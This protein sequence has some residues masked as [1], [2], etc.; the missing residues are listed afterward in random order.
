ME[1]SSSSAA[2]KRIGSALRI[3]ARYNSDGVKRK[4]SI[5]PIIVKTPVRS[6]NHNASNSSS[7]S[8]SPFRVNSLSTPSR[9]YSTPTKNGRRQS[10]GARSPT[11]VRAKSPAIRKRKMSLQ[12][13]MEKARS[14]SQACYA[15]AGIEGKEIEA[16]R[17]HFDTPDK[18]QTWLHLNDVRTDSWEKASAKSVKDLWEEVNEEKSILVKMEGDRYVMRVMR[19]V[20]VVV[21][22]QFRPGQYRYLLESSQEIGSNGIVVFRKML[23]AATMKPRENCFYAAKRGVCRELANLQSRGDFELTLSD[24]TISRGSLHVHTETSH[25]N[26]YPGL[27]TMYI[28]HTVNATTKKKLPTTDFST[29]EYLPTGH[30]NVKHFWKWRTKAQIDAV[31]KTTRD[32]GGIS[33]RGSSSGTASRGGHGGAKVLFTLTEGLFQ[34]ANGGMLIDDIRREMLSEWDFTEDEVEDILEGAPRVVTLEI[35][36]STLKPKILKGAIVACGDDNSDA[37]PTIEQEHRDV[38]WKLYPRATRLRVHLLHGGF[39]GAQVLQ[40]HSSLPGEQHSHPTVVKLDKRALMRDERR[41][42][43]LIAS[44]M[45]T[46]APDLLMADVDSVSAG[47]YDDEGIERKMKIGGLKFELVG[48]CWFLPDLLDSEASLLNTF[49]KLY[50]CTL[51]HVLREEVTQQIIAGGKEIDGS[52]DDQDS[53]HLSDCDEKSVGSNYAAAA[54]RIIRHVSSMSIDDLRSTANFT[55]EENQLCGGASQMMEA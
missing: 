33:S 10:T 9:Q 1:H 49:K 42:F 39:G 52:Y 23:L 36:N 40:V 22:Q 41:R 25:S 53:G 5:G 12:D 48:A 6:V 47:I 45:G 7:L 32:T 44:H 27:F 50:E 11:P 26:S 55:K 4:A 8:S 13:S 15:V 29:T 46:N 28:L 38:L 19:V 31:I 2:R 37:K 24:V 34:N 30:V 18:L 35:F 17:D 3:D 14:V 43:D 20:R 51:V 21:K 16:L 54:T